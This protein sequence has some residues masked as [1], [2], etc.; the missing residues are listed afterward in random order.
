MC[1]REEY[2]TEDVAVN[3][4]RSSLPAPMISKEGISFW[5]VLRQ[6]IGRDLTR[7]TIPIVF[8][9]PLSF[10]QRLAEYMEYYELLKTADQCDDEIER[11]EVTNFVHLVSKGAIWVCR[12]AI[13]AFAIWLQFVAAFVISTF[14]FNHLRL[15]KPFNP[16]WFETFELDRQYYD[17]LLEAVHYYQQRGISYI[18]KEDIRSLQGYRFVAEQVSHH[19]PVSAFHVESDFYEFCGTISPKLRFWG[20]TVEVLPCGSFMLKLLRQNETY[21]WNSVNV[22]VH[23][24]V[25][26]KMYMNLIGCLNTVQGKTIRV[27]YGNWT[28]LFATCSEKSFEKNY[29]EWLQANKAAFDEETPAE[30]CLIIVVSLI[31]GSKLLWKSRPRPINSKEIYNFTSFTLLMNDPDG[32]KNYLPRTDSRFRPDIRLLEKGHFEEAAKEKER[33]EV[34]QR[35]ARAL[36]KQLKMQKQPKWFDAKKSTDGPSWV[37]N[38]QY[39]SRDYDDCEDIF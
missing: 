23:N 18:Q 17:E 36:Q 12:R 27:A 15:S 22:T 6:S 31:V 37:F 32:L 28:A 21:M 7:I 14:A 11:F 13:P 39:W 38:R 1:S 19:P 20:S 30:V 34:K 2:I 35:Q 24:I 26:G 33:L 10:L 5:S 9:E 3:D 29:A 25:M 4:W 16:L 8:N